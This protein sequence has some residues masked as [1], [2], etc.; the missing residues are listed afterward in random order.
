MRLV[1][2]SICLNEEKTIGNL[3]D[4][5][6]RAIL[7][8]TEIITLVV[9]DGSTDQTAQLAREHGALVYSN[10]V[11]RRLASSFQ[12]AVAAALELKADVA[13]SI[14]GDLQY[15]PAFIPKLLEPIVNHRADFVAADRFT[16]PESC[17]K[18]RPPDMPLGKY[19]GNL[20]GSW[21]TGRLCGQEF[22]DVTS[23]FRA[24]SRKA[25]LSLNINGRFTYT[26]ESFQ[27]LASQGL[28]IALVPVPVTYYHD[29]QS[30]VVESFASYVVRSAVNILR[31]FRDFAPLAFF[32]W[33]GFIV[34][35]AGIACLG[36]LGIHFLR[37]GT[38]TPYKFVGFAGVFF[39]SFSIIIW[40]VGLVG[41]MLDRV[42]NSQEKILYLLKELRYP[43]SKD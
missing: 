41:D 34:F 23:G 1:V 26:Q 29:R 14:D 33:L 20:M 25:L 7:G 3:L 16:D 13:V 15:D 40:T 27:L 22:S 6:P 2:F 35:L 9:D 32:G 31:A 5:I 4:K 11:R 18:R 24:Y 10:R 42:L 36:L 8:I 43:S 38:L 19:V 28:D 12:I 39:L 17:Q 21:V 30:R 37:T